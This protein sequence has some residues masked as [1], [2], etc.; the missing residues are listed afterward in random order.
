[1]MKAMRLLTIL[2]RKYNIL[3]NNCRVWTAN[4]ALALTLPSNEVSV[5]EAV[6][7]VSH[8]NIANLAHETMR[9]W[10]EYSIRP[11]NN[12]WRVGLSDVGVEGYVTAYRCGIPGTGYLVHTYWVHPP[13]SSLST[14]I[15]IMLRREPCYILL[16]TIEL[17]L[18]ITAICVFAHGRSSNLRTALWQTGGDQGWNSN[19]R[20]RI[21]FYANHR[22]P[23]DIPFLW[24]EDFADSLLGIAIFNASVWLVRV[25]V[26][27]TSIGP[28]WTGVIYDVMLSGLWTYGVNTQLSSDLTDTQHLSVRPWYLERG[29]GELSPEVC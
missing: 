23:P 18:V 7:H 2:G 3:T 15:P 20:L 28:P 19:P 25:V 24:R 6:M 9:K 11:D 26:F 5:E 1:M 10:E 22:E 29:C 13:T 16:L 21:Y 12:N 27:Q 14:C 8:W 4:G 17:A